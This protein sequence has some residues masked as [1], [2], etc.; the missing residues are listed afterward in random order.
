MP[1]QLFDSHRGTNNKD[2]NSAD[3]ATR[4]LTQPDLDS[5]MAKWDLQIEGLSIAQLVSDL[6]WLDFESFP[7]PLLI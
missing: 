1:G 4:S 3:A 6:G 2:T 5:E 7:L